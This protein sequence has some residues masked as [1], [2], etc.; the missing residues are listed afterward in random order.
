MKNVLIVA[1]TNVF[2]GAE[3]VLLDYLKNNNA[4]RF[5]IYTNSDN[6]IRKKIEK[7]IHVDCIYTS[8][9]MSVVSIRKFPLKS[10]A[11]IIR[12]LYKIHQ[13]VKDNSIDVLY[14]NNTI[15]MVLISLYKRWINKNIKII[16]HIHDIISRKL[17]AFFIKRHEKYIDFFIVPS[18]AAKLA[19]EKFVMKKGKINVA[20]NGVEKGKKCLTDLNKEQIG[21]F[22]TLYGIPKDKIIICF[23]GQICERKRPDLFVKI[24]EEMDKIS[25]GY[26]GIIIGHVADDNIFNHLKM[27]SV[28]LN[29]PIKFLGELSRDKVQSDIYPII[30]A[31]VLTSDRDPLP[32]VILEA[33]ANQKIVIARDVDG[34]KEIIVDQDSGFIFGYHWTGKE[35]AN[36]IIEIFLTDNNRLNKLKINAFKQIENKFSNVNK[37][38]EINRIIDS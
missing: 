19:L 10:F 20:Y 3:F 28:S 17:Y 35:I 38:K 37:Q 31:L 8:N 25:N 24:L 32:T 16:G 21:E 22:K 4:H 26:F 30:D 29:I 7:V 5:Y 11:N 14:G 12:N 18:I 27:K 34:V 15:D 36:K 2:A 33:M 9:V 1:N 23:I 13:I 6:S